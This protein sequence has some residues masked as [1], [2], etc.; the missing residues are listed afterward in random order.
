MGTHPPPP[1]LSFPHQKTPSKNYPDQILISNRKQSPPRLYRTSHISNQQKSSDT[2]Q[3][4]P[5]QRHSSD[6]STSGIPHLQTHF[7]HIHVRDSSI[8]GRYTGQLSYITFFS[9]R[10]NHVKDFSNSRQYTGQ[11]SY[12]RHHL[13]LRPLHR[14]ILL[15]HLL[16]LLQTHTRQGFLQLSLLHR[17]TLLQHLLQ[18]LQFL[19]THPRQGFLQLRPLHRTIFLQHLFSTPADTHTS[20]T[21]PTQ[22]AIH[23]T[24][25]LQHL[26]QFLQTYPCQG[27]LHLRLLHRTPILRRVHYLVTNLYNFIWG[28]ND[29]SGSTHKEPSKRQSRSPLMGDLLFTPTIRQ[30]QFNS[31]IKSPDIPDTTSRDFPLVFNL[32]PQLVPTHTAFDTSQTQECSGSKNGQLTYPSQ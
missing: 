2:V 21:H 23:R 24:Y 29:W 10:H 25:L 22:A 19:Q 13:Q 20:R 14:T 11:F 5:H 3:T 17:T 26:L 4:Y 30:V 16:Q 28:F 18:F 9:F 31:P 32:A 1:S 6:I 8:S 27:S 12:N 7:R 15:Q